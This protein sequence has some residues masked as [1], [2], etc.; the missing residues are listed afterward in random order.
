[1]KINEIGNRKP[2]EK[3]SEARVDFFFWRDQK[4]TN[5]WARREKKNCKIKLINER[6]NIATD[7]TGIQKGS[8]GTFTKS[9]C[10][11]LDILKEMGKFLET[12]SLQD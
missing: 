12:L 1:M 10:Q 3:T 9:I 2:V 6:G 7:T 8:W 4:L 5:P 11:K